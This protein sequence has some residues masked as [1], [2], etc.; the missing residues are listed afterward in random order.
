MFVFSYLAFSNV[1]AGDL[2]IAPKPTPTAKPSEKNCLG[3]VNIIINSKRV[4]K[5]RKEHL[6]SNDFVNFA[7]CF[8]VLCTLFFD[9]RSCYKK[10]KELQ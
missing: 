10:V 1:A 8:N 9:F 3:N 2:P 5:V 7:S 6:K 4:F